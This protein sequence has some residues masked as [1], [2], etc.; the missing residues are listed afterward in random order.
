VSRRSFVADLR[1]VLRGRD[2]RRLFATRLAS[3]AGDGAFQVGLAS[4]FFFSP[5]RSATA[6][7][8]AAAFTVAVLPYTVI[9]PIA[10]VLLDI[11]PRRQVLLLANAV[12]AAMVVVVALMVLAGVG[13]VPLYAVVLACTSVNRF[14]LAGLGAALP[15]VVPADELVMANAVAPT[16][17]TVAALL[18]GG[19]AYLVRERLGPASA[20]DAVLLLLAAA[21]YAGSAL[22]AARMQRD[23]LG[24]DLPAG[25]PLPRWRGTVGVVGTAVGEVYRDVGDGARHVWQRRRAA[26]ALAAIGAH[27]F[28]FGISTIA[29]ILLCRNYLNDPADV[30]AGLALLAAVIAA[31]GLGIAAAAL[32]TPP[33]A[34][35]LGT[36]GWIVACFAGAAVAEAAFVAAMSVPLLYVGAFVLG[37]AAQGSKI[38]VDAIVQESV[39]DEFRGRVFSFYDMVFNA[40]FVAA[41][42][43]AALA[44]PSAG[45]SPKVYGVIA[46][47]Y[48]LTA[49]GYWRAEGARGAGRATTAPRVT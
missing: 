26:H 3:Q 25:S 29:T 47:I 41:A 46:A 48:A 34:A 44:V 10:G 32:V 15:H 33:A 8:A 23:L 16:S 36:S 30:D 27:R 2:F 19:L 35:R 28:A 40:A 39:D 43:V 13:G 5:E 21:W 14:F 38:C 12:R 4:L 6:T 37:V 22:L 11:W 9:G 49:L 18:G 7:G 42:A 45:F 1:M 24:P 17:G 31:A 20:S